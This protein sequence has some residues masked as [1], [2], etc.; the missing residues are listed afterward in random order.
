MS[1]LDKIGVECGTDKSSLL[2]DY[3]KKYE[4]YLP[5]DRETPIKILEIGILEGESLC[6]WKNFFPNSTIIGVDINPYCK[7]FESDNN[8]QKKEIEE[9][10]R[11]HNNQINELKM[12]HQ[13]KIEEMKQEIDN[14]NKIVKYPLLI[15]QLQ[16]EVR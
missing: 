13:N 8:E 4:K 9:M 10:K 1:L 7:K 14:L 5:F 3:L 15:R 11:E 6:V 12:E 16:T 2:H